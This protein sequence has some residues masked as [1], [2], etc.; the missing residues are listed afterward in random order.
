MSG[1][2]GMGCMGGMSSVGICGGVGGMGVIGS[3]GGRS[4][5]PYTYPSYSANPM[6]GYPLG[7]QLGQHHLP[8]A[9]AQPLEQAV[10]AVLRMAVSLGLCW[11]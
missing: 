1:V 11:E 7:R 6:Q 10:R 2:S 4:S 3:I 8:T 9:M 5:L